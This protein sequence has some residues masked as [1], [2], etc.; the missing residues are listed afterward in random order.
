MAVADGNAL[1]EAADNERDGEGWGCAAADSNAETAWIDRGPSVRDPPAAVHA[2][3]IALTVKTIALFVV[4]RESIHLH[5][6]RSAVVFQRFRS[7]RLSPNRAALWPASRPLPCATSAFGAPFAMIKPETIPGLAC[8]RCHGSLAPVESSLRCQGCGSTYPV[9]DGIPSFVPAA[10]ATAAVENGVEL[11]VVLDGPGG[12]TSDARAALDH[13]LRE[14]GIVAAI[15]SG[16]EI[17]ADSAGEPQVGSYVLTLDGGAVGTSKTLQALWQARH[18]ADV[19]VAA[20]PNQ[21]RLNGAYRRALAIPVDSVAGRAR[22]H[23]RDAWLAA[24]KGGSRS[25]TSLEMLMR[26][27]AA[28]YSVVEIEVADAAQPLPGSRR[29]LS[30]SRIYGL[31]KLRN[32]IASAD[33]DARAYDSIVPL[34]RYWQRRRYRI[35]TAATRGS[36]SVL[37][38][39]CGSSRILSSDEPMVGLDIQLHKLRYA[40][41]YGK[42]LVHGSIFSLP[43]QDESFDCVVCSEVIEHV[44]AEEQVFDELSRV[45]KP[46]G[47]L[48]LG[49]P[50]YDRRLWRVLE[51]LYARA[52]PGGYADE[53]IT[54]YSRANLQRYLEGRGFSVESLD[55]VFGAEMIF[56]LKK[57]APSSV[58]ENRHPVSSGL[59][60]HA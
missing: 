52:A 51:W 45:L 30:L 14:L 40:R 54:H 16:A 21:S 49:T 11:T 22:I 43:F 32:S 38:V 47:R 28:G 1:L 20:S 10:P 60:G 5:K 37:D 27:V 6:K 36:E 26:V 9:I 58:A 23:R 34:Q 29:E 31:W 56:T 48:V 41:R 7:V 12:S 13:V 44:P 50:D 39:G 19:V 53:H 46:G 15:E 57:N 2:T 55:Y 33:Y 3:A 8:P 18:Q 17:Q 35:I 59:R 42:P 4:A 24:R 25:A